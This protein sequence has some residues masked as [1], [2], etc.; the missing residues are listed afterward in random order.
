MQ[1]DRQTDRQ[2]GK[3]RERESD[4]QTGQQIDM[5]AEADRQTE[6]ETEKKRVMTQ[7]CANRE[8]KEERKKKNE[9][10]SENIHF[11][12]GGLKYIFD[13]MPYQIKSGENNMA[14]DS[15]YVITNMSH[16]RRIRLQDGTGRDG[17]GQGTR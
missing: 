13:K 7:P 4:R 16:I 2:A 11:C 17:T 8:K 3:E 5:E 12:L 14:V 10:R 6:K 1:I 9:R 15:T